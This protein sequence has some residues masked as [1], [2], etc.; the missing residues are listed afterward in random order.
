MEDI[1]YSLVSDVLIKQ[2]FPK[3]NEGKNESVM[4][5]SKAK[6]FNRYGIA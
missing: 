5:I 6:K 1:D 3:N 4:F 2:L